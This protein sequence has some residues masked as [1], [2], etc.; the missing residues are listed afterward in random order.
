MRLLRNTCALCLQ[1]KV[2]RPS[3]REDGNEAEGLAP[4]LRP[5]GGA[6]VLPCGDGADLRNLTG[7]HGGCQE[8]GSAFACVPEAGRTGAKAAKAF[9]R[10]IRVTPK[11]PGAKAESMNELRPCS[12]DSEKCDIDPL[13]PKFLVHAERSV[14]AMRHRV[15]SFHQAQTHR[16]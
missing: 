5:H 12:I 16:A 9:K 14:K 6:G 4:L 1:A 3:I 15:R 11:W 10:I 2:Q 13:A 7:W 8:K